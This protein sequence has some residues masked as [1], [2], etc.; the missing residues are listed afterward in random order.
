MIPLQIISLV[1]NAILT[2]ALYFSIRELLRMRDER[3][4]VNN[5]YVAIK[6]VEFLSTI[7]EQLDVERVGNLDSSFNLGIARAQRYIQIVIDNAPVLNKR[8]TFR[9]KPRN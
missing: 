4:H 6:T 5:A 1:F 7:I 3:R 9:V 2:I 8:F